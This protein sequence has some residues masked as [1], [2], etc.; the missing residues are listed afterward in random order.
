MR[1]VAGGASA[2]ARGVG[3]GARKNTKEEEKATPACAVRRVAKASAPARGVGGGAGG[4]PIIDSLDFI[5]PGARASAAPEFNC[6]GG[7]PHGG[8]D[9]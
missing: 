9:A 6:H 8:G 4:T 2:A 7:S 3:G 1:R 5:K